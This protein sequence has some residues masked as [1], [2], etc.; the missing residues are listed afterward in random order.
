MLEYS[1]DVNTMFEYGAPFELL[2]KRR[3]PGV[4]FSLYDVHSLMVDIFDNP[5][6]YLA[7]PANATGYYHS[8]NPKNPLRC[9]NATEPADSFM[10]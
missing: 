9:V 6:E 4:S 3:W 7:S 2:V 1:T 10:W 8:C 5:S